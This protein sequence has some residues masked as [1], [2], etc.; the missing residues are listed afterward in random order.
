MAA[1]GSTVAYSSLNDA[2]GIERIG[3]DPGALNVTGTPTVIA[4]DSQIFVRPDVS[5]DGQWVAFEISEHE[6]IGIV[7]SDG[8]GLRQVTVGPAIDRG[9]RWSPDGRRIAFYSN[10]SGVYQNWIV[11]ADGSGVRQL[12]AS[13][14][15]AIDLS[16]SPDG[17]R[18]AAQAAGIGDTTWVYEVD[19]P[20]QEQVPTVLRPKSDVAVGLSPYRWSPDGAWL[21]G[22]SVN[23]DGIALYSFLDNRF[24]MLTSTGRSPAWTPDGRQLIFVDDTR[25]VAIDVAT[26]RSKVLLD[27]KPDEIAYPTV[28]RDGRDVYFTR[29]IPESDV[30]L[31]RIK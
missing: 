14:K 26:H 5:P 3:F 1:D 19:R 4:R 23:I 22:E 31:M 13:P 6:D 21:A 27:A 24:S 17:Q 9:P 28:S 10:R 8:T 11:N 30:W 25:L 12:T 29:L 2:G 16:W 18:I 20:W 15:G 7:R